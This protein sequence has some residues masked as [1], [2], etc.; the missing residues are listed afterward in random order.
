M[1]PFSFLLP[2]LLL[3]MIVTVL[4]VVSCNK[5]NNGKP[6]L[7]LESISNPV[8]VND[9]LRIRFK[10]S[11][12]GAITNG[13]LWSIRHRINVLPVTNQ[14]GSDTVQFDLPSFSGNSGELYLSLPWQGYLNETATQN[15]TDYFQFFVQSANDS[16]TSDTVTTKNVV[17]LFQ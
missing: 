14:S 13:F 10:F 7:S 5:N 2:G 3:T 15:D 17:I 12:G 8:Q 9:S 11:G 6:T 1:K 4:V 16:T